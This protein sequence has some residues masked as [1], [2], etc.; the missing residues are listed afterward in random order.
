MERYLDTAL[1]VAHG[2]PRVL[3]VDR[4]LADGAGAGPTGY[5]AVIAQPGGVR[6]EAQPQS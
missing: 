2:Q 1:V 5:D 3:H 6:G 4:A